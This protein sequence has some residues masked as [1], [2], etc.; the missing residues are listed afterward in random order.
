V[1]HV[2]LI[3]SKQI[4]VQFDVSLHGYELK[5]VAHVRTSGVTDKGTYP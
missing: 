3:V 1:K 5:N 4:A 2:G